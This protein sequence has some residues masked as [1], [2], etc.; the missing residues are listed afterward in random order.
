MIIYRRVFGKVD[1]SIKQ[2]E[3]ERLLNRKVEQGYFSFDLEEES[4][5]YK[6]LK[7]FI[8]KYL[9]QHDIIGT[10]FARKEIED[11]EVVC[12]LGAPHICF[13]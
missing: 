3:L 13:S 6:K 9:F 7:P 11:A 5:E 12:F 10:K 1:S 2:Q 4:E 8:S